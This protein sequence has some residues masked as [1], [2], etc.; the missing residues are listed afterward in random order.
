VTR[1][2][3]DQWHGLVYMYLMNDALNANDFQNNASGLIRPPLKEFEGG[4]Q[5]GGYLLKNSLY[6]SSALDVLVSHGT[7]D[8]IDLTL[9]T[10]IFVS[11]FTLPGG[12][13]QTLLKEYPSGVIHGNT[14]LTVTSVF[15]PPVTIDH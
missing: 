11:D 10:S 13:A 4:Y 7:G 9:P 5:T 14:N 2:G 1:A 12:I 6:F 3:G 8:P 15:Q